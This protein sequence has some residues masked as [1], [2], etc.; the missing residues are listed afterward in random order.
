MTNEA[1]I[2]VQNYIIGIGASAGGMEAI[3]E[4]FDNM[5]ATTNF[6]FVIVQHLSSDY[7]S[8]MPELLSRHTNMPVYVGENEMKLEPNNIY[9]IPNKYMMTVKAKRLWLHDKENNHHPNNAVDIFFESLAK[10][11]KEQAVGIILS[12]TGT[13]GTKGIEQ[14]KSGGGIVIVQDPM[15]AKFDGMPNSAISTGY[16]DLILAPEMMA[17]EMIDYL[18]QAPLIKSFNEQTQKD[19]Y[20]VG[21][22]LDAVKKTTNY[23]F[24][25]YKKPTILR[26]LAKRMGEVGVKSLPDYLTRLNTNPQEAKDLSKEFLI[27][28][29][30]FFR[31]KDAYDQVNQTVLPQLFAHK[32]I[33][34]PLKIW[35]VA[36]STGEEAYSMAIL[37]Q[38][39][40]DKT[41]RHDVSIKIFATDIDNEALEIAS[42]GL[43]PDAIE[44]DIPAVL[45]SKYFTKEGNTY[46]VGPSLRKMVVFAHHDIIND[47]PFSKLDMI[48]CR[49]MLIYMGISLQKVVM[50]A[51]HFALNQD[52]FLFLGPSENIGTLK[53][54]TTEVDRKWKIYKCIVKSGQ[55]EYSSFLNPNGNSGFLKNTPL[56]K[57]KNGLTYISDI[58]KETL[59]EEQV[60]AGIFIDRDFDIKQATGHF[61]NFISFPE[62]NFNFNLL[63][64]VHPD[65]STA[66]SISVR[67]AIKDNA[68][69]VMQ[70]VKLHDDKT[71]RVVDIIVKPYLVQ[72]EYLQPFL[73][74]VIYQH[75]DIEKTA[76]ARREQVS[77]NEELYELEKELKETRE[78]LQA[79][80]EE[81]ES[82]NEELQTS[83][84]EIISSN[85]ELQSTNEELQSLNEELHT[86]N[87]EHQ[88]KIKEL[89]ELNDDMNN[90][91]RNSDIGQLIIDKKLIIRKF[92]PSATLQ[93]NLIDSDIGRSIIDISHNFKNLDFINDIKKVM[94]TG[95]MVEK[96]VLMN[97][98]S[99]FLMK[100]NPYLRLDKS[101]DG[102]V[103][104]FIDI[105]QVKKLN[106]ILK[107]VF[108]SST[109]GITAKQAIRNQ[110][111][112]IVDFE[113]IM[114][115]TKAAAIMKMDEENM[116]GKRMRESFP[117]MENGYFEKYV[118][119]VETGT[120]DRFEFLSPDNGAWYE[121]I[122]VKMLDGLVTTFTDITD[123]KRSADLLLRG[124]EDL[125]LTSEK[126]QTTNEQ[127]E[128]SNMDL[129]Q[130]ASIASHDLKEPLRKIQAF[131]NILEDKIKNKID[132]QEKNY[133]DKII[134]ASARMQNLIED[135]LTFSRLSNT[136]LPLVKTPLTEVVKTVVDDLEI[137]ISAKK[138]VVKIE[139]LPELELV[140]AQM[141]QLFHNLIANALKFNESDRPLITIGNEKITRE[142][143][144]KL[145]INAAD[146][147]AVSVQDNGIGFEKEFE[148]KIFKMFQRLNPTSYNGTG[149]GLA[150]CRKI[151]ENHGGFICAESELNKGAKFTVI[152]PKKSAHHLRKATP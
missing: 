123:K 107:A 95:Q 106:S 137:S 77:T 1:K 12:G 87:V 6:T 152:L 142:Q 141:H 50:K 34:N 112:K 22:I 98:G 2:K 108:N 148:D 97:N 7:K 35:V 46:K 11:Y 26:R 62:G 42:R 39:F 79:L 82:A 41:K 74:I 103:I 109:S 57:V 81:V 149:I 136:E 18:Q 116:I 118:A 38:E 17:D 14:I 60:Y 49:N 68:R 21:G 27:R 101:G 45:L 69:V 19:D 86:V 119:V 126:L 102:V 132:P 91:F 28:V 56:A 120:P 5:P 59:L 85:E 128:T 144:E 80:I 145:S 124:Y 129:Y 40:I 122:C 104:S 32:G 58:F 105:S 100:L 146:Y 37:L 55:G 24:R 29:T 4:L 47:P 52:G 94:L 92:T 138:A 54:A 61:K 63:K 117:A 90:Y 78:N 20:V 130:F 114:S 115:N 127:L 67:K 36:C 25:D 89:V 88:L 10:E 8:L 13:D 64:L 9:L 110:E 131:G 99:I 76:V 121:V 44:A 134:K 71:I 16:A 84:E 72:K 135:V 151:A 147:I 53:D 111:N 15:S 31:D 75:K 51:F 33:G 125:K 93:V 139:K 23:D 43:Y 150:I 113:Y 140:T 3:H 65:L 83:N 30:K 96:E 133:L 66:V 70:N 48:S 143:E 73:F